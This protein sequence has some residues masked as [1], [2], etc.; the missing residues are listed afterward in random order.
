MK[1]AALIGTVLAVTL[2]VSQ[3]ANAQC[4]SGFGISICGGIYIN[5]PVVTPAPVYVEPAPTV[6]YTAPPVYTYTPPPVVYTPP[7]QPVVVTQPA[8]V[9]VQTTQTYVS[10]PMIPNYQL[11][12]MVRDRGFGFGVRAGAGYAGVA[13]VGNF[14]GGVVARYIASPRFGVELTVDAYGGTG[15]TGNVEAVEFPVTL[16][17]LWFINP[18]NRVQLYLIGGLGVSFASVSSDT[19]ED[20]PVYGGG[21]LGLGVE[22]LI[23]QHVGLTLDARGFVRGRMNERET[24]PSDPVNDGSCRIGDDSEWE[25]TALTAGAIF[26]LGFNFYL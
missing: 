18:R 15:Y 7:P 13:D 26:N 1:K 23:G 12:P 14:G 11:R 25:C 8:P 2:L 21:E 24:D 4:G 10:R 22:F 16:N 6:V 5:T 17:G 19:A 20:S 9:L 3:N